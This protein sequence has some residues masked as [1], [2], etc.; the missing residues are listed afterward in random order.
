VAASPALDGGILVA[1]QDNDRVREITI[2]PAV[3]I[4]LNPGSPNGSAGWYVTNPVAS[5][6]STQGA[7]INCELDPPAAPPAF[8][9][10][11]PGCPF[12]GLGTT[13]SGNGSHDLYAAAQNAFGDQD[14]PLSVQV[15]I[16]VGAPRITCGA[17]PSFPFGTAGAQVTATLSDSVS[18]PAA[19]V[20][21][22]AA[23]DSSSIGPHKV[24]LSGANN[25]GTAATAT[26]SYT[27]TPL[28]FAPTPAASWTFAS[29]RR[30]TTV[31]RLVV[32][33]VP[34]LATVG[35]SCR[36]NGCPFAIHFGVGSRC[37]GNGCGHARQI[38]RKVALTKLFAHSKLIPG[39]VLRV[40][41]TEPH[42]IGQVTVFTIR[43]HTSPTSST[44]CLMPGSL[45][46]HVRCGS[47]GA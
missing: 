11:P 25:A 7:T 29:G 3:T 1:D 40:S 2:P 14:L 43:S 5:V 9:A 20:L 6:S 18:G 42:A 44:A 45:V 21:T 28:V 30:Y 31:K 12:L 36:G 46:K 17:A 33:D 41:V 8:G 47:T 4:E 37:S 24:S 27:V 34:G 35:V 23:D 26:C 39:T 16:D 32:E 22:A 19:G 13:I 38:P 15:N 10:I